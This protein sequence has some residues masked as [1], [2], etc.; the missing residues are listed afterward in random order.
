MVTIRWSQQTDRELQPACW[1]VH[2][3]TEK[4]QP[5]LLACALLGAVL[6]DL[7]L[8]C[9]QARGVACMVIVIFVRL[10]NL[11]VPILYKRVRALIV[12][13]RL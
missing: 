4:L 9:E 10:L 5:A 11:A 2:A 13:A 7:P 8:L 3:R 6:A 1:S 12:P